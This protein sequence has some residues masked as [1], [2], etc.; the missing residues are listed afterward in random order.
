M[1]W[2][3]LSFT[4]LMSHFFPLIQGFKCNYTWKS[5]FQRWNSE[6]QD[7]LGFIKALKTLA[8]YFHIFCYFPLINLTGSELKL[9]A[10]HCTSKGINFSSSSGLP[11]NL[12][13]YHCSSSTFG[14]HF[15]VQWAKFEACLTKSL[16][17]R[18]GKKVIENNF[19][20][21]WKINCF[22]EKNF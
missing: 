20:D 15:L 13:W 2:S 14:F 7:L 9:T 16:L 17:K 12:Y 19:N 3:L 6:F 1:E 11:L 5:N 18:K 10:Q 8:S 4:L 22:W 21:A